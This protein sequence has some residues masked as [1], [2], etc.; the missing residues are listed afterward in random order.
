MEKIELEVKEDGATKLAVADEEI[1]EMIPDADMR[2]T[3]L[4][5]KDG[6]KHFVKGTE[7][8]IRNLL[9]DQKDK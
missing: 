9:S 7:Q 2:F 8:E 6:S 5:L 1:L 4:I 3:L